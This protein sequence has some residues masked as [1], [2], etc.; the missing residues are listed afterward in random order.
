MKNIFLGALLV[1]SLYSNAQSIHVVDKT[2]LQG[3]ENVQ[4]FNQLQPEFTFRTDGKGWVNIS[5]IKQEDTLIIRHQ[6]YEKREVLYS[7]LHATNFTVYMSEKISEFDDVVISASRFEEKK[8]D[9]VQKIQVIR[10]SD[11]Q[12]MNQTSTADMLSQTGNILVQKSQQGGGSPIIRGFETN[13]VLIV[14]DGV[15]MNNAI[16]RGGHLQNVMTLDNSILDRVEVAFG[17]SSAV[18]GSDALGGV[19]H[20]ITKSPT[21]SST[22]QAL[23]KANAYT[24]YFSAANGFAVHGDVSVANRRFGSL[25]SFT[26]SDFGDLMQ[27]ANRSSKYPD[28]GKRP[29][30]QDRINGVDTM[31]QNSN[32]NKQVGSSYQQLD[33]LQKFLW[34]TTE[35]V[36]QTLNFQYSTTNNVPRYDRLTQQSGTNPK[37]AEWNYGPQRRLFLSYML[38]LS[39]KTKMYDVSRVVLGYQQIEESR[40]TRR[41]KSNNRDSQIEKVDVFSINADFDKRI[42]KNEIRYGME[43]YTNLVESTANRLNIATQ[44]NTPINTRYP[45]G[46]SQMSGAAAYATHTLEL[47]KVKG[48]FIL[49][50]GVRLSYIQ[51]DAKFNDKSFF[52]FPFSDISQK[53][54]NVTGNIGLVYNG[55]KAWRATVNASTGFRAPNVD[56]LS[57]V[58]ESV[59][60]SVIVP[61]PNLKAE[62]SYNGEIGLSKTIKKKLTVSVLGYY[63]LLNSAINVQN[64]TFN[65]S[66]SIVYNGTLSQVRT[67]VNSA[68]AYVTGIEAGIKGDITKNVSFVG[69]LNYTYG[70]INTDTTAYPLDHI[71]PLFGRVGFT[72]TQTKFKAEL[73]ANYS[74]AKKLKDYNIIGEDNI[75]YATVDGTPAWYTLNIRLNYQFLPALGL[76][77]ACEN[78]MD[79]NY[80]VFASNISAPGRNFIG[81]LRYNF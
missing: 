6:Y 67:S 28:F 26:V 63:T 52:P 30:Y 25:T 54:T 33:L 10:S 35:N 14:V 21:L 39:K 64:S 22:D 53:N 20:F 27:G 61:N 50:E 41:F 69:T 42:G 34:Q 55:K 36:K 43:V 72:Y 75:E 68:S 7:E 29:W 81:T 23:V 8:T 45:D 80:R 4:I 56:D 31:I 32:Q 18:Y 74:A 59:V 2:T 17:P 19:M 16:Y 5:G 71:A 77:L 49:S 51:L 38:E 44:Y 1:L 46:G 48:R 13:R 65:G 73:F 9:V 40:I 62:Y 79:Q 78:I 70:R 37:Y 47:G 12:N 11:L 60:G 76:Q 66:D 58:F 57:K 24:R 3:I 15:R